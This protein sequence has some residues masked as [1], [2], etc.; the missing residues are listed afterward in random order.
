[1]ERA[2]KIYGLIGRAVD[3]SWSPLIHNTAFNLLGLPC[4]YTIFNI[5]EA[6]S[7]PAALDGARAL[8][9]GGFSVTIPYKQTVLPFLDE[10]SA[11]AEAIG[12]VNTIVNNGGRLSGY[13]TDIEGFAAPLK[14]YAKRIEGR[15]VALFGNGGAALA[16]I[17]AFRSRYR[18]SVI[19]LYVRDPA[20]L[21]GLMARHLEEGRIEA[22]LQGELLEENPDAAQKLRECAVIVNATPIGTRGRSGDAVAS[23]VPLDRELLRAGQVVYDMVYN[24]LET[25]L[26][27]GA[28][29]AGAEPVG[30]LGMLVGQAARAFELWTGRAM[31]V[32]AVE[33]KLLDAIRQQQ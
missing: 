3:Y 23:I 6:E 15:P 25:P 11:E 22:C 5:A 26:L 13:N 20:R 29:M 16:A 4:H 2:R 19:Y 27:K 12:A 31:P 14:P 17:E 18:P 33:T 1:M 7:I 21:E 10:L 24:P 30:G 32:E 8:G 9:L 28:R